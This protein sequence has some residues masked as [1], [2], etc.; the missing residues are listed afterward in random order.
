[1]AIIKL[2]RNDTAPQLRLSV[3][4][5]L[6]GTVVNLTGATVTLH[7]RAANSTTVL[8]SRPATLIPPATNGIAVIAWEEDD[9]DVA[10]GEYEGEIEVV[11]ATGIR[12]T[13]FD[14][15]QFVV[16]EEFA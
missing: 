12:E 14:P 13:I 8:F 2:V 1:M 7:F 16:R 6:T 4:D 3:T 11:L 5:T 15:L 9:L 10:A